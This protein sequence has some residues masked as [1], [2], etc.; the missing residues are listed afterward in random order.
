MIKNL[1]ITVVVDNSTSGKLLGEHGLSFYIETDKH[2]I[3]FDAG[4][5]KAFESNVKSLSIDLKKI[6]Y[7]ILS[8]GHYDHT[9]G[10]GFVLENSSDKLK[11]L[12]HSNGLNSKYSVVMN[13][14]RN[15]GMSKYNI[16]ALKQMA[17][18][19]IFTDTFTKIAED[20]FITGQI[21]KTHSSESSKTNFFIDEAGVNSDNLQDDQ[22][23][24]FHTP[25][26]VVVL[27]GCCHSGI[28][29]TLDYI[30]KLAKTTKIYAVIGGMHLKNAPLE[31][32]NL[33]IDTF[34]KYNVQLL[35]PCHCTGQKECAFIYSQLPNYFS[36]C[37]AGK[38]FTI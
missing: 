17:E 34:K 38:H 9:N 29:N 35:A 8:H 6:D 15:I 22:A 28:A 37:F 14:A 11:T 18:K 26:G 13:K 16:F 19:L 36:E 33:A 31:R 27:L 3:L 30:A 32:M 2:K 1:T 21:P 12:I 10:I 24:F 25:K 23:M 5:G 4:R 20:I 7:L